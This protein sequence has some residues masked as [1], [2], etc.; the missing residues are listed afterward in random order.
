MNYTENLTLIKKYFPDDDLIAENSFSLFDNEDFALKTFNYISEAIDNINSKFSFKTYF[1]YRFNINFNAKAWKHKNKNVNIIL[2]NHAIVNDLEPIIKKSVK[3]FLQENF[4]KTTDFEIKEEVLIELFVYV[5]TSYLFFHELGH[6]LQFNS[7]TNKEANSELN[8]SKLHDSDYLEKNHVYEIDADL[9]GVSIG[10][11]LII[12]F[13]EINKIDKNLSLLTNLIII[14]VL[15]IS[16]IFINFSNKFEKLYYKQTAYPHPIIRTRICIE[17][18]LN[19]VNENVKIQDDYFKVIEKKYL[20]LLRKMQKSEIINF[21]YLS[22]L[23][24]NEKDIEKY[25]NEIEIINENY[26]ELTRYK[27]QILYDLIGI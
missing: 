10:A 6:I 5:T 16:N 24:L 15:I 2:L 8:E 12:Q 11:V 18:I 9:F 22:L 7:T 17:Q 1:A 26:P 27:A 20:I 13:L 21:D 3:Y 25:M 14:F 19:I 23:Q 4:T